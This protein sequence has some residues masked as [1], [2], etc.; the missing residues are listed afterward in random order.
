MLDSNTYYNDGLEQ[1]AVDLSDN[2]YLPHHSGSPLT[3]FPFGQ[4]NPWHQQIPYA[5]LPHQNT[6]HPVNNLGPQP[7]SILVTGTSGSELAQPHSAFAYNIYHQQPQASPLQLNTNTSFDYSYNM[8]T[9]IPP[10]T[11]TIQVPQN[12]VKHERTSS[13]NSTSN[14]PTPVSI[15]GPRS[16]LLSP[17][18]GSGDRPHT[19]TSPSHSRRGSEDHSSQDGD[20]DGSLRKNY[21]YK[22][23]EDPPR[24]PDGKMICRHPDC[25]GLLFDRKCEW[26]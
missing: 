14:M 11:Q 21:S 1:F 19:A 26:R 13:I 24:N 3:V 25:V 18:S 9:Q 7:P 4:V 12:M 16:P 23:S 10:D 17:T 6:R 8:D 5:S 15:S 2:N 22:R 20:D